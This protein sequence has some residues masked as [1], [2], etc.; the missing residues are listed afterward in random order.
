MARISDGFVNKNYV[1]SL[2]LCLSY[3]L[4]LQLTSGEYIQMSGRAGR[5][6]LDDKG[7]VIMMMDER[8]TTTVTKE[9]I[10]VNIHC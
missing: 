9:M 1:T 5:R 6:G 8:M 2:I 4:I 3:K 10:T 7:I